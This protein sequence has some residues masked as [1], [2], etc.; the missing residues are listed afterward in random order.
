MDDMD[1]TEFSVA[2][3]SGD[4][5]FVYT[6]GVPEAADVAEAQYSPE[7]LIECLNEKS[8]LSNEETVGHVLDSIR[9][10]VADAPQFDDITML[11]MIY[12]E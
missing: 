10:F 4:E 8:G 11:S 5:L 7:R 6:D 12:K 3:N 9:G 2:F 1:L